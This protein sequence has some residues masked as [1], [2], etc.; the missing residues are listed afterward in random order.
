MK[1]W[2]RNSPVRD[3]R[4]ST[5]M[6]TCP[7]MCPCTTP[8]S[9]GAM[10]PSAP[11]VGVYSLWDS[12]YLLE[13]AERLQ[14]LTGTSRG[15]RPGPASGLRSRRA[16][17][18]ATQDRVTMLDPEKTCLKTCFR[19][20]LD[21]VHLLT[22]R[23]SVPLWPR[24]APQSQPSASLRLPAAVWLDGSDGSLSSAVHHVSDKHDIGPKHDVTLDVQTPRGDTVM[25]PCGLSR[26]QTQNRRRRRR[27]TNVFSG[28]VCVQHGCN[29][30]RGVAE[31]PANQRRP[32]GGVRDD[33][34]RIPS[35]AWWAPCL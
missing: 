1:P 10:L 5:Q 20:L 6:T 24:A 28:V 18:L 34:S 7:A 9:P 8:C 30:E 29:A 22:W 11:A 17:G 2:R 23:L 27:K 32:T 12:T 19:V 13:Q 21:R 25:V 3:V 31:P 35:R 16:R 4:P 14:V 15:V 26:L 33:V